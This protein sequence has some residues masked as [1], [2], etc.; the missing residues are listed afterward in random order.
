[1]GSNSRSRSSLLAKYTLQYEKNPKSRVFAPLAEIYRKL[2]M[3]DEA[4]EL[5]KNGIRYHPSYT[6]GYIVL[7]NCYYDNR[8]YEMAYNTVRP[9]VAQNLENITLQKLF[10]DVCE[11]LGFLEE[12]L[13]TYKY[14]LLLNPR[15]EIVANAVKY[16]EEDL[17]EVEEEN[18]D[19]KET[20]ESNEDDWVQM[21]FN[22]KENS[23]ENSVENWQ[24]TKKSPLEEFKEEV[25]SK[26]LKISEHEL[27]DQFFHEDFDNENSEQSH[28]DEAPIITHTLVDLYCKQGHIDKAKEILE[29]ILELHPKD[30]ATKNR[31]AELS[32][33]VEEP[34]ETFHTDLSES[35]E[36][37]KFAFDLFEQKLQ[38]RFRPK[39]L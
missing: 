11:K 16:L 29:N 34:E 2:G 10:G 5:L 20:S 19:L 13:Q 30:Q 38:T 24:V 32:S 22:Q 6:L 36:K 12:A 25:V 37:L 39:Q 33:N 26:K 7:A 15:D 17:A 8:N 1:L 9:F 31:L 28:E 21:N 35:S 3:M 4:F 23:D 27:D 14:L 18:F